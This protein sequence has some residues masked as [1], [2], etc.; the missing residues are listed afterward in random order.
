M[1]KNL[2]LMNSFE[3][4][5]SKYIDD[6]QMNDIRILMKEKQGFPGQKNKP[7]NEKENE[8]RYLSLQN[9]Y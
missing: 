4:K 3:K 1:K 9:T 6:K 5:F 2:L 8:G 7:N